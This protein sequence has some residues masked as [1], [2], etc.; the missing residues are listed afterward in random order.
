MLG[1]LLAVHLILCIAI[2]GLILLQKPEQ[3]GALGIGGGG[4]SSVMSGTTASNALS[5]ATSILT[6][7]FFATSIGLTLLA[8]QSGAR[9]ERSVVEDAPVEKS[10]PL[11]PD[12]APLGTAPATPATPAPTTPAPATPAAPAPSGG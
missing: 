11:I 8:N 10:A 5:R 7:L 6:A 3:G 12:S 9:E 2:T 4:P 1:I